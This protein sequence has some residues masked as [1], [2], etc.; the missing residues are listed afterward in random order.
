MTWPPTTHQDVQTELQ[1]RRDALTVVTATGADQTTQINTALSATPVFGT[2]RKV[3]LIGNFTISA[4]LVVASRTLLDATQATITL[5]AGSNCNM[6]QNT[7]VTTVRRVLDAAMTSGSAT[8]TSATAAFV[9][10]DVG[11]PVTVQGAG[12]SGVPL[13][14]T[15][16][17]VTNGTTATLAATAG[18]TVTGQY[19]AIGA[20]DSDIT[21]VGGLWDR[22]ANN[23][24][25]ANSYNAHNLRFR[26]VD[27]LVVLRGHH[28]CTSG[29]YAI[30]PG[31]CTMVRVEGAT[32]LGSQYAS[33]GVHINGPASQVIV[34]D[35]AAGT[36]FDDLV[37]FT[38]R[39][40]TAVITDCAGDITDVLVDGAS[41]T[42]AAT[43]GFSSALK[44]VA[45]KTTDGST[46]YAIRRL[47]AR[48]LTSPNTT[49]SVVF[50][51]DPSGGT[52]D[53]IT[54][55]GVRSLG[56]ASNQGCVLLHG[57]TIGRLT[58]RDAR[59]SPGDW[60]AV[61]VDTTVDR[62]TVEDAQWNATIGDIPFIVFVTGTVTRLVESGCHLSGNNGTL[63]RV[64]NGGTVTQALLRDNTLQG[65]ACAVWVP[66]A[67]ANPVG[68]LSSVS[69][70]GLATIGATLPLGVYG[71][72]TTLSLSDINSTGT[73]ANWLSV[74]GVGAVTVKG[75][76]GLSG[77]ATTYSGAVTKSL[78]NAFTA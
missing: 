77:S 25:P 17:A 11:K 20:R 2:R 54:L 78:S 7:A 5:A 26:H 35:I 10:G 1:T 9:A 67:G 22:G 74:T 3:Q 24:S 36:M 58:V 31:D 69:I 19:A 73:S 62:L 44:L 41:F 59:P 53:D 46:D 48:N 52:F 4:P 68:V 30:N 71:S 37:S 70:S 43:G 14:T 39:D 23:S 29:K 32:L 56:G 60:F 28:A 12:A 42:V 55:E 61:S 13:T 38:A 45:G 57:G 34:R 8:L 50:C 76:S 75:A 16:S 40:S 63:L 15:I 64:D 6:L 18:T 33:D 66:D 65:D 49:A 47:V 51:G 72:V 27:G 21:I